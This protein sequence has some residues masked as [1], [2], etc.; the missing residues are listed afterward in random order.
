MFLSDGSLRLEEDENIRN[1]RSSN[2][3]TLPSPADK[4]K[5]M[6]WSMDFGMSRDRIEKIRRWSQSDKRMFFSADGGKSV[7]TFHIPQKTEYMWNYAEIDLGSTQQRFEAHFD[8]QYLSKITL[9]DYTMSVSKEG[10]MRFTEVNHRNN[11]K[12]TFYFSCE[13]YER[14]HSNR[15]D[16]KEF[17]YPPISSINPSAFYDI[18]RQTRRRNCA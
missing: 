13:S 4:L 14:F 10:A 8:V 6:N 7:I 1:F 9:G 16:N 15:K 2:P 18:L 12:R 5:S 3:D 17:C 11:I